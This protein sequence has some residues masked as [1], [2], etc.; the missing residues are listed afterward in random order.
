[1]KEVA[2]F[3]VCQFLKIKV[4]DFFAIETE[5]HGFSILKNWKSKLSALIFRIA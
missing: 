3:E 2:E 5:M 4:L 1:M